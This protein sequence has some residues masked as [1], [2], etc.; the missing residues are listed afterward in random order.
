MRETKDEAM[1]RIVHRQGLKREVRLANIEHMI[2]TYDRTSLQYR[3]PS[4]L[5]ELAEEILTL[6]EKDMEE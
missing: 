4:T 3:P 2:D 1:K 5:H 6:I